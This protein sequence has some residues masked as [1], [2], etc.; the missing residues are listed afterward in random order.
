MGEAARFCEPVKEILYDKKYVQ[1]VPY[2]KI[3]RKIAEEQREPAFL[4]SSKNLIFFL[5]TYH[6]SSNTPTPA[7]AIVATFKTSLSQLFFELPAS[8][9]G[10]PVSFYFARF[11]YGCAHWQRWY[12]SQSPSLLQ[13][14]P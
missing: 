3:A 5:P 2:R 11:F 14:G 6:Q 8:G 1:Y 4:I 13:A 10:S 7:A 9:C 12:L